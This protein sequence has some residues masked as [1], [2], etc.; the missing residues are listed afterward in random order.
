MFDR[1]SPTT[2]GD[3]TSHDGSNG[4]L[5]D[6]YRLSSVKDEDLNEYEEWK[7]GSVAKCRPLFVFHSGLGGHTERKSTLKS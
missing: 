1:P 4:I 2:P 6:G 5:G 7:K 3:N